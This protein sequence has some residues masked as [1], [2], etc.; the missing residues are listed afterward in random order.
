MYIKFVEIAN[1]RKL[2]SVRVD[3]SETTTLFVGANNSGKTSAMV[4]LRKFLTPHGR[5][6][7]TYDFT[8]CHWAAINKIGQ[9]WL[10]AR[11]LQSAVTFDITEWARLVPTLDLWFH[12]ETSEL[13]YVR[14]IIPTLDWAGG[15]LGVRLRFEPKELT[16]L[17]KDF[18]KAIDE[19]QAIRSAAETPDQKG[20]PQQQVQKLTVWRQLKIPDR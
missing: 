2:L 20:T 17:Y 13:H 7:E 9:N 15:L 12:V 5:P 14:N 6:F 18:L 1:F 8:L 19:A 3:L 10:D 4:A 11:G 16:S